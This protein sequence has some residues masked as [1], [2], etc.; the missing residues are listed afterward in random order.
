MNWPRPV[1]LTPLP[2]PSTS[3]R[4]NAGRT[5]K[6]GEEHARETCRLLR[7]TS[8]GARA[9][10]P[11]ERELAARPRGGKASEREAPDKR[12]RGHRRLVE[13]SGPAG[14]KAASD[15]LKERGGRHSQ[16]LRG[17]LLGVG[18]W[19]SST[20]VGQRK[21]SERGLV[22]T[23]TLACL[24]RRWRAAMQGEPAAT[25]E[26]DR[27]GAGARGP[28]DRHV[29]SPL[30]RARVWTGE[31]CS[32]TNRAK[33][34]GR[35]DRIS[36]TSMSAPSGERVSDHAVNLASY[37]ACPSLLHWLLPLLSSLTPLCSLPAFYSRAQPPDIRPS[38]PPAPGLLA[39]DS[40]AFAS[41]PPDLPPPLLARAREP[42][43]VATLTGLYSANHTPGVLSKTVTPRSTFG[44][45]V[46]RGEE[47]GEV[48]E[49]RRACHHLLP[50]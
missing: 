34:G 36:I 10:G 39:P 26:T 44:A 9:I 45:L 24:R 40:R 1:W 28:P 19:S 7:T 6:E 42:S 25:E 14:D 4:A 48:E 20:E 8:Y 16:E 3:P 43:A 30:L 46:H 18:R 12:G 50:R 13:A 37:A 11:G 2:F 22:E 17:A 38:L 31:R 27:A 47:G 41:P 35:T 23:D 32:R 33:P 15:G 49:G 5:K 21:S 29:P